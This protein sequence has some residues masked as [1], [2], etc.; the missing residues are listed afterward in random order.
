MY[1]RF[2]AEGSTIPFY[3]GIAGASWGSSDAEHRKSISGGVIFWKG[4]VIKGYSRMQLCITLSSCQSELIAVCQISQE[5][6]G[7]R[8]LLVG[9]IS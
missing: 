9:T 3:E 8:H 4:N 1:Q 5:C 2:P 6:I 7:L